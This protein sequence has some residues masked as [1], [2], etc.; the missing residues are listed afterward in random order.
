[1]KSLTGSEPT[2]PSLES[3]K[4]SSMDQELN[5]IDIF[6]RDTATRLCIDFTSS[7]IITDF[8]ILKKKGQFHVDT[9]QCIQLMDTE[10]NMM[11]KHVGGHTLAHVEKA[12]AVALDQYSS[13]K[14]HN[15][16][17]AVLNKVLLN[18]II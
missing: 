2:T 4:I 6:I 5:R 11:N 15:S 3:Y 18:G 16:R 13:Q 10:F 1:M 9:M 12:K 17:K 8:Q 7:K 14:H